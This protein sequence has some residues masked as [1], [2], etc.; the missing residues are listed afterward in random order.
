MTYASDA[1]EVL[2][3]T[4]TPDAAKLAPIVRAHYGCDATGRRGRVVDALGAWLA[5]ETASAARS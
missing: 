2:H 5:R 4:P 1:D 3:R